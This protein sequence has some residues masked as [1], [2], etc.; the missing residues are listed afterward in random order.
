MTAKAA[1]ANGNGH[2]DASEVIAPIANGE[3]GGI[4]FV[5]AD[6]GLAD[7]LR[8]ILLPAAC[9]FRESSRIKEFVDRR[10]ALVIH[11]GKATKD[12]AHHTAGYL[13]RECHPEAIGIL[14]TVELGFAGPPDA[15]IPWW[16][17]RLGMGQ[18]EDGPD[19]V[20]QCEQRSKWRRKFHPI[21]AAEI[22]D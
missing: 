14:D 2:V 5:G 18:F 10:R 17:D 15:F 8:K 1:T 16:E 13:E 22:S 6:L 3:R 4:V 12:E 19:F 7:A 11:C 9:N 21:G 20:R